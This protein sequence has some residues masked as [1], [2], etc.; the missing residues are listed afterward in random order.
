MPL[1]NE[2]AREAAAGILWEAEKFFCQ[3]LGCPPT[4][5]LHCFSL[6]LRLTLLSSHS[7]YKIYKQQLAPSLGRQAFDLKEKVEVQPGEL[8]IVSCRVAKK[9]A[10]G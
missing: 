3:P 9:M 2:D 6:A 1:T 10:S 7:V 8:E 4:S 5:L